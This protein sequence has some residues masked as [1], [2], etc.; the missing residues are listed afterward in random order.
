MYKRN[1]IGPNHSII[2][3]QDFL[4]KPSEAFAPENQENILFNCSMLSNS[5]FFLFILFQPLKEIFLLSYYQAPCF[6]LIGY[7]S[8]VVY[9]TK[10]PGNSI[11]LLT[12]F[13]NL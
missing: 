10:N 5:F 1:T 8:E 4:N 3:S 13:F 7:I 11:I 12:L 6:Y 9:Q 2:P